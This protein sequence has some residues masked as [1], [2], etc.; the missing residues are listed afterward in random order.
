M[1]LSQRLVTVLLMLMLGLAAHPAFAGSGFYDQP[2]LRELELQRFIDTF[3]VFKA[4]VRSS[5]ERPA[6]GTDANGA[7][8]FTWTEPVAAK[9]RELG[10]EPERFFFVLG[11]TAAGLAIIENGDAYAG[12][13][14]PADMPPVTPGELALIQRDLVSLLRITNK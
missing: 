13:Q 5:G 6:P 12:P 2:P 1:S 14:R 10:W 4:W 8:T 9:V 7:P 3:P 11:K